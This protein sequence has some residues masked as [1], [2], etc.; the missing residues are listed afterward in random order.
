ML[1]SQIQLKRVR[2]RTL[3]HLDSMRI[4]Y[5]E[6]LEK[7]ATI[8]LPYRNLK[9]QVDWWKTNKHQMR[10][11]LFE[12]I[13]EPGTT[14]GFVTLTDRGSFTTHTIALSGEYQGKGYGTEMMHEYMHLAGKPLAA[15]QLASNTAIRSLH[16]KLGWVVVGRAEGPTGEIELIYHPG[17]SRKHPGTDDIR[18]TVTAYLIDK[19]HGYAL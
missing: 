10:A 2:V 11:Y 9:D 17:T 6:N 8:D 3:K 1:K 16:A 14:I 15:S 12:T 4:I 7:L 18:S 13:D 19:Y 5:N